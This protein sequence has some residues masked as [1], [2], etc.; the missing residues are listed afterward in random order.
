MNSSR[1]HRASPLLI[2]AGLALLFSGPVRADI[3]LRVTPG[4]QGVFANVTS[5]GGAVLDSDFSAEADAETKA[6]AT[7]GATEVDAGLDD[8]EGAARSFRFDLRLRNN[9]NGAAG[10]AQSAAS[11]GYIT[12]TIAP[13]AA[14]PTPVGTP[15]T[16]R[17]RS[18]YSALGNASASTTVRVNGVE[19]DVPLTGAPVLFSGLRVGDTF[20]YRALLQGNA[21]PDVDAFLL[22]GFLSVSVIPEPGTIALLAAG[23]LPSVFVLRRRKRA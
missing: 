5:D 19:T 10:T 14:N 7:S 23:A 18:I 4:T 3:S 17:A 6:L 1:L 12:F 22:S 16:L 20:D 2:G 11:P 15:V 8:T 13:D 9:D 21:P